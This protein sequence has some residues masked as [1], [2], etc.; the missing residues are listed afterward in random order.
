MEA[1]RRVATGRMAHL[2]L[3]GSTLIE[4]I[5]FSGHAKIREIV[6]N[7]ENHCVILYPGRNSVDLS[8]AGSSFVPEGKKL[9][10]FVIDGTWATAGRMIRSEDLR[11]LPSVSFS[12]V[13]RSRFRVRKQP[14]A[15]CLSTIEAIHRTIDL[16]GTTSE[17][18][19]LLKVFD[20]MVEFQLG[21]TESK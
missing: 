19:S 14:A 1:R 5:Q 12:L 9:V 10:V 6:S 16:L 15:E 3:R 11:G 2:C 7:P 21:F 20:R 18:D 17:H 13:A 4:G 8:S